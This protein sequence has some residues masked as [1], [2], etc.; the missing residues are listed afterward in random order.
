[1]SWPLIHF[2]IREDGNTRKVSLRG[3]V[4]KVGAISS[5]HLRIGGRDT[6][7]SRMHAYIQMAPEAIYISDLGSAYGTYVNGQRVNK[8]KLEA[9]DLVKFGDVEVTIASIERDEE[10][11]EIN[12]KVAEDVLKEAEKTGKKRT[13]VYYCDQC[14]HVHGNLVEMVDV[15]GRPACPTCQSNWKL[16]RGQA[17][18]EVS[19]KLAH[20][21]KLA[22]KMGLLDDVLDDGDVSLLEQLKL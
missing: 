11:E 8:A 22:A 9:G 14:F 15:D 16:N 18:H 1:M 3:P 13:F 5:A 2:E 19:L 6:S 21:T 20:Y 12:K 17:R 4:I 7:A 10:N